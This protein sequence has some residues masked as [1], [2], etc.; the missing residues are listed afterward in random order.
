MARSR[1]C[2]TAPLHPVARMTGEPPEALRRIEQRL[3]EASDAAQRLIAEAARV[4]NRPPPAGWQTP[5]HERQDAGGKRSTDLEL[6]I[7]G[8]RAMGGLVPPEVLERLAAAVRE[9]L[10]A[11]RALIDFYVERL[12]RRHEEHSGLQDIP[13]E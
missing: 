7:A 9:L 8:M 11:V 4:G 13:I 12:E 3:T 1:F 10:L 6:L 2:S 5:P